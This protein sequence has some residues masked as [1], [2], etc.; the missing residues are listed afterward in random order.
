MIEQKALEVL[1]KDLKDFGM[2]MD[3]NI[4]KHDG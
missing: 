3:N 1:Y 4:L 2:M